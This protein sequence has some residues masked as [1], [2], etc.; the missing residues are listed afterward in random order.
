[1]DERLLN[2]VCQQVY[3]KCP[4]VDGV[5]PSVKAQPGDTT[6]LV[7]KARASTAS[8][9]AMPRTVRVTVNA[10][11]KITKISSSR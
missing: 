4:E 2:Q 3:R 10:A 9:A 6:L 1:M 8:G 11:G 5:R 7:F